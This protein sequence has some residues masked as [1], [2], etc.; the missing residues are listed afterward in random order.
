MV[1]VLRSYGSVKY[2]KSGQKWKKK[3]I[4]NPKKKAHQLRFDFLE[5]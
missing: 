5:S 3:M 2:K 4:L 1:L